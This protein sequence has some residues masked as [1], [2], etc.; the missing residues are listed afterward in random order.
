MT[1]YTDVVE[2]WAG[3]LTPVAWAFAQVF[4][5]HRQRR[6]NRLVARGALQ[7]REAAHT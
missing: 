3:A 4:C 5:R 2:V 6:L 1:R 7:R